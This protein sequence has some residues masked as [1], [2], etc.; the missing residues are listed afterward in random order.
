M[1]PDIA[2]AR[3][4]RMRMTAEEVKLW[5]R[6]GEWRRGHGD[7]FRR[8]APVDGDVLA[9]L[10][11]S[12]K[13]IVEVDGSQHGEA[14]GMARDERRDA[15]FRAKRYRIVRLWNGDIHRDPDA[16]AWIDLSRG[17]TPPARLRRAPSQRFAWRREDDREDL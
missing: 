2:F 3:S 11:K 13:L 9:F 7:H 1:K 12:E 17:D 6:L 5:V 4:L 8:E 16:A 10:C 15:H 14:P